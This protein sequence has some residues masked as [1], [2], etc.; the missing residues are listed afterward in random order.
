VV[1][2]VLFDIDGTL[3]RTG[4]AGVKAFATTAERL[5]QTPDGTKDLNFHGRTDTAIVREFLRKHGIPDRHWN[6]RH[7]LDAYVFLLDRR[8]SEHPGDLC[9]GVREFVS[10][11]RILSEPPVIGLLTG[12]VRLG[13]ELKLRPHGLWGEFVLGAFGDDHE[14]R[15]QLARIAKDR[16][17]RWLGESLSGDEILVIGDTLLD[18]RCA[19]AIEARCL[20]VATGGIG[21]GE[22]KGSGATWSVEDLTAISAEEVCA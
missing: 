20:A 6:V 11:L 18:V 17:S 21:L 9:P 12:N 3:I 5:F 15:N 22:L 10:R 7:F 19:Q 4:G 8:M 16:G 1:R 13:A 14:D 2:L